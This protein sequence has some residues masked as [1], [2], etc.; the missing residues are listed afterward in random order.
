MASARPK[1]G[2]FRGVTIGSITVSLQLTNPWRRQVGA[3]PRGALLLQQAVPHV[4]CGAEEKTEAQR[5]GFLRPAI[6]KLFTP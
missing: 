6:W 1:G 2:V 3:P 4:P 5:G